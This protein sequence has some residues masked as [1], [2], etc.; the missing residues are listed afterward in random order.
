MTD[1]SF[2]ARVTE[3]YDANARDLPWREP[4][5][6]P[7]GVLVSEV[8]LAQT[9]VAR[10]IASWQ[11]WMQ[12]WPDPA[13]LAAEPAGEAVRM[14]GRLGYP[15]RALRLHESASVIVAQ[16]GGAVPCDYDDLLA[17]PGV[18]GYTA[19]AVAAFAFGAPTAVLDTNVR[20]VHARYLR[21]VADAQGSSPT[22]AE[23]DE[24]IAQLPKVTPA[25]HS[26]AVMELGAIVCTAR[27]PRCEA[28]PVRG[29][30]AWE[31]AG[32]PPGPPSRRTQTYVGTDRHV[33]GLLLA[34]VRDADAAID[35]QVLDTAWDDDVQRDRALTTLVADG[36]VQVLADGRYRLPA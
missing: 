35:P 11:A 36:L 22:R 1:E 33:R 20:R 3:W 28:C 34:L 30:C 12:R 5:V 7:W 23:Y 24:A 14:W 10:V 9:P 21:G 25:R 6:S 17:L 2:S 18:G 13:A 8:M 31:H 26:V 19:A 16:H 27:N 29:S 32:R 4:D 15:R